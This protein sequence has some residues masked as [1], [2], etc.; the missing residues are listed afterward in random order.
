MQKKNTTNLSNSE[1]DQLGQDIVNQANTTTT[2]T[3]TNTSSQSKRKV[4]D[5]STTSNPNPS[6]NSKI[7]RLLLALN[8]DADTPPG[9]RWGNLD[10][11][12]RH[13]ETGACV[14]CGNTNAAQSK[15]ML[16]EH[17][18]T[19]VVNCKDPDSPNYHERDPNFEYLR[20]PIAYHYRDLSKRDHK[21]TLKYFGRFH[22][23]V[24]AQLADGKSVLIHC[25][26]GAHRA[27]T[28]S[29]SYV[30]HAG[31]LS[32]TKAIAICQRQRPVINPIGSFPELLDKLN[33]AL[34]ELN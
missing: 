7:S 16:L 11:L 14:F 5:A 9:A 25:L 28:A 33:S 21:S 22:N 1:L 17:G 27:G 30:M 24:D 34:K 32:K 15:A 10:P 4:T 12:F 18:I 19:R 23:W 31:K 3:T 13:P 2:S 6:N 26:A 8:F 20:F 29:I